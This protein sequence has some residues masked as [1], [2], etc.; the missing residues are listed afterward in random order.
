MVWM[1]VGLLPFVLAAA[2]GLDIALMS[3]PLWPGFAKGA[4]ISALDV[5]AL[6]LYLSL[7]RAKSP[8]PFRF[9]MAIYFMAVLLSAFQAQV[10]VATLFYLWQLAR[11]FL[12]YAV[13][14]RACVDERVPAALLTGM[15]LGLC[16]Q[17]GSVVWQRFGLG[18]LQAGGTMGHQNLLGLM[19]HFAV[20]PLFA[21]LLAGERGWQTAIA[22][23]AGSLIAVLTASRAT[24]G[25]AGAGYAFVFM[26]SILRGWTPRKAMVAL[27]AGVVVA[28]LSPIAI[29]SLERRFANLAQ[30]EHYDERAAFEK[31]AVMMFSDHPMGVGANNYVVVANGSGYLER[32]GV[33]WN[34]GSR[35]TSVHNAYWLA[36]AETGY[37]G[38]AVIVFLLLRPLTVAFICGWRNPNDRRGDLLLGLG[39]SLLLV[40]VHSLFEWGLF[41]SSVQY[42]CAMIMGMVA[43]LAQQLGYWRSAR[44]YGPR[45]GT[46]RFSG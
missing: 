4:E 35:G 7:P 20:F 31:A 2:P 5:I 38:V 30:A 40:A 24:L 44:A 3:L 37:L 21:L 32:A 14:T 1:L 13:V 22:P 46:E 36:A 33:A 28:A 43:G 42:S 27:L 34:T 29:S 6:A 45:I 10:P 26:L 25:L 18:V 19:S 12:L 16:F 23:L 17:A 8:L 11:V 9:A 41:L 39:T 15:T